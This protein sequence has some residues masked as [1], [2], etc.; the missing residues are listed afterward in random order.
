MKHIIYIS[1]TCYVLTTTMSLRLWI[2]FFFSRQ[3]FTT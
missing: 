1:V 3:C 2:L